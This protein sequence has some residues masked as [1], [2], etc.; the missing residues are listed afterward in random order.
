MGSKTNERWH[1]GHHYSNKIHLALIIFLFLTAITLFW[2]YI[3]ISDLSK[4]IEN[5]P[6]ITP[7]ISGTLNVSPTPALSG[8]GK[9]FCTQDAM[10]CPDGSWV[11]RTGPKCQ[12]ICP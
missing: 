4:K 7:S 6:N 10:Q 9:I 8:D 5:I 12:F 11:G 1:G 3:K 2:S